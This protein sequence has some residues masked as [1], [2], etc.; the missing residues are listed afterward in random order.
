MNNKSII[1]I[2][3]IFFLIS[4]FPINQVLA[5]PPED[6]MIPGMLSDDAP[7]YKFLEM[8]DT[9]EDSL[10]YNPPQ[11]TGAVGYWIN[12]IDEDL[13]LNYIQ[14]L[15]DFGPR[16]TESSACD[17]AGTY[18]YNEFNDMGLTTRYQNWTSGSYFGKNVEATL[19]G[20]DPT[21]DK[22]FVVLG[23]YD[24]VT[25]SPGADDNAGGTTAALA[26]AEI[27]SQ[28]RFRHT[29]RFLA[30]DGEEQGLHGSSEYAEEAAT[31]GDNIIAAL[32]ADMIGFAPDP[33]DGDY[34]NIYTN[35]ASE[36]LYY[37]IE[38][39]SVN[40]ATEL[41]GLITIDDGYISNSDHAS[42]VAEG[43]DAVCYHEYHFN[44]YYHS[45]QDTIEHMNLS[46]D[47]K[48]TR[49]IVAT[50]A[51]LAEPILYEHDVMAKD[52]I[53]PSV[54]PHGETQTVSA[55]IRN[56]GN[57]TET[58]V[59]VDFLVDDV[60]VD[61]TIIPTLNRLESTSVNFPWD[62]AIG[63]YQVGIE[64][65]PVTDEDDLT[66][67]N[68][69]ETVDVIAAPAISVSPMS[70][71]FMV[72]TDA[73]D[74]DVFT[75]MNLPAAEAGLDYSISYDG[76]LGGSW[77]SASPDTGSLAIGDNEIITVTVDTTGLLEGDYSGQLIISTNDPN[78]PEVVVAVDLTVVYG[79][80]FAS[81]SV[82]SPVGTVSYGTYTVNATVQNVGFYDQTDVVVN[83]SIYEGYLDYE[84]DFETSDGDFISSGG[85]W[86][87]GTPSAGPSGA[88]SGD[89]CWG[90]DL[91]ANYGNDEDATLDSPEIMI[92]N[93]VT[94]T[95]SFWQYYDTESY[96]D[97][98]NVK[99]STD[100]GASWQLLGA[101]LDPYPEDAASSNNEG[102][103]GEPCFSS[104]S[105]GWI[106][107]SFD[108]TGFG[109]ET[110]M[111]RW[112][113]GSDGSV[114]DPGWF[115]DDILITGEYGGMLADN[116][117][118]FSTT[119]T[120]SLDAYESTFV[121]FSP[122]WVAGGGNYTIQITTLLAG[123]EQSSND[124]IADIVMVSGPTLAFDPA[125]LDF[126]TILI[127]S[128]DSATF[129]IWNDGV[130]T[131]SYS[132]SES[133]SWL[134]VSPISGDSAGEHDSITVDVDT[135]GL[136][137][138]MVYH[139]DI[140]ISSDGGMGMVG[141]DMYVVSSITPLED[142]VQEVND[143][144]FPIRHAADGDWA[145]AQDFLPTMNSIAKVDLYLRKFGTPEFD[146]VVELREGGID[147]MLLD[148]VVFTPAEVPSTWTWFAVDFVDTPVTSGVQYFIVCPPAPSG[149]TTSFGYEWG[150]AFGNQYDDGS[151]WFTRDS[152]NLWRD[153]PAMYEFT[154]KTYG[155]L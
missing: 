104:S 82:N 61:S 112:H 146:L 80:D 32:N 40:Y 77:L 64:V 147:G 93:G 87:Y 29:I 102:I 2:L 114:T 69:N 98:G 5:G 33:G 90:T 131:L 125:S 109:G 18:I 55:T 41:N 7:Y 121:E 34:I 56:G 136:T 24:S 150:Y 11:I 149:V 99:I 37:Y 120:I 94:A 116:V 43:Y 145:G 72:P 79:N 152:G 30:V 10:D 124:V 127:D 27:L 3:I 151:F 76:D 137:P 45:S 1:S 92:P 36:W 141:V 132:V 86:E 153:L 62:P 31:N 139:A 122:D 6:Q 21:S 75:V 128:T 46:Y 22:V 58:N 12:Q 113:F 15:V 25:S 51:E 54:V 97:G 47:A 49:L 14:S 9:S 59:V 19:P 44:S 144:G 155:L 48:I 96:Y 53:V 4:S 13:V 133:E 123:D 115:I 119:E 38:N 42:F 100:G 39:I 28:Y 129:D 95:L 134:D 148:T 85:L 105:S 63:T 50:L 35:T 88:H 110:I 52:L 70:L 74:T 16:V 111:L 78:D 142:V 140:G 103:P 107:T 101:Y 23:H 81:I 138:G 20:E 26:A 57:N 108:L 117:L 8:D 91:D 118:V 71:S 67:N 154:F 68:V 60:I 106:Q 84:Q 130:G 65:Q 135:T 126:G 83:C 73:Q 17:N 66:N 89:Y 143:R